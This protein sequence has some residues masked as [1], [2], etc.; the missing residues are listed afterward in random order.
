MSAYG[1]KR[2]IYIVDKRLSPESRRL[3][4]LRAAAES[5]S[6]KRS[7]WQRSLEQ[8]SELRP[9]PIG[10]PAGDLCRRLDGHREHRTDVD[11]AKDVAVGSGGAGR[12]EHEVRVPDHRQIPSPNVQ[13][14]GQLRR[15]LVF[16]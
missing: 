6:L 8:Q 3:T 5:D 7:G 2:A 4:G 13:Q 16:H 11:L 15:P 12:A 10:N 9:Q 14:G 1:V